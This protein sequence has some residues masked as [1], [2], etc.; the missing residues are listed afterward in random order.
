[1]NGKENTGKFSG[2]MSIFKKK[3]EYETGFSWTQRTINIKA[4]SAPF[5]NLQN[6]MAL[7]FED[8]LTV[9]IFSYSGAEYVLVF[10]TISEYENLKEW[11]SGAYQRK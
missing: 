7:I 8:P 2:S 6:I 4:G 10:E 3:N 11:V 9:K 1:M 5:L